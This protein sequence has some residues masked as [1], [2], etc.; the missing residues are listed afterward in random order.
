MATWPVPP[1]LLTFGFSGPKLIVLLC[2]KPHSYPQR[3]LV[4]PSLWWSWCCWVGKGIH[5]I[6]HWKCEPS[7]VKSLIPIQTIISFPATW[8]EAW[9]NWDFRTGGTKLWWRDRFCGETSKF[10]K[11]V[12]PFLCFNVSSIID[13]V[14]MVSLFVGSLWSSLIRWTQTLDY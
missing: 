3:Q 5:R 12:A 9:R 1:G 4:G 10:S 6:C 14:L 7:P 11:W 2:W 8:R 13:I